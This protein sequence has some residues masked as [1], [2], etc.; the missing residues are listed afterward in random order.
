MLALLL[1]SDHI[2]AGGL[3]QNNEKQKSENMTTDPHLIELTAEIVSSHVSKNAVS[4]SDLASLIQQVHD[5]LA[6]VRRTEQEPEQEKRTPRVSVKASV[7]PDYLV[8]LECGQKQ[9]TLKRHLQNAH[10][11]T[12][13]QYRAEFALP[14]SYP[15]TAPS[16]SK[17]RSELARS[18]GLGK[19]GGGAAKKPPE[20]RN[21]G[22]ASKSGGRRRNE[23]V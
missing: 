8:C 6:S 15:M 7:K 10:G 19:K 21:G 20:E 1:T 12:A 5:A 22:K 11:M 17:R 13:D 14:S 18:L 16:Y 23:A 2:S 4:V 9:K 3:A